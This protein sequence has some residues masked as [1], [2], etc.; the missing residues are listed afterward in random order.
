MRV[1][2]SVAEMSFGLYFFSSEVQFYVPAHFLSLFPCFCSVEHSITDTTKMAENR[3]KKSGIGADIER[4]L[5][6]VR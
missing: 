1:P 2:E 4:K 3:A 6:D 5:E